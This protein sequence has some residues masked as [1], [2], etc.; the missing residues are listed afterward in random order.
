MFG[1]AKRRDAEAMESIRE[2]L[3]AA[4]MH[5]RSVLSAVAQTESRWAKDRD[6]R[7][8]SQ[9]SAEQAIEG[10]RSSVVQNAADV[11]NALKHV[12]DMCAL[13]V[14]RLEADRVDR[15][16]LTQ[17]ITLL[18]RQQS[19]APP[20]SAPITTPSSVLGGTII[21]AEST[22]PA[23]SP[24][25]GDGSNGSANGTNGAG[26]NGA[27]T[28]GA[29]MNGVGGNADID[30]AAYEAAERV[31]SSPLV[32]P[33]PLVADAPRTIERFRPF[34][35]PPVEP[36]S[37]PVQVLEPEIVDTISVVDPEPVA[38]P[39]PV[40]EPVVPAKPFDAFAGL[41][42]LPPK[43]V[44]APDVVHPEVVDVIAPFAAPAPAPAPPATPTPFAAPVP[45]APAPFAPVAPAPVPAPAPVV[46]DGLEQQ[47]SESYQLTENNSFRPHG[48]TRLTPRRSNVRTST[49]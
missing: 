31:A 18:A 15:R 47:W 16:E 20:V 26:T 46:S 45:P 24:S 12:S 4:D 37:E 42:L 40:A 17:A 34:A 25:N 21:A 23:S 39:V 29:G 9:L 41:P 3:A 8:R 43:P 13:V 27:G 49:N 33:A 10:V 14:E 48:G 22:R 19:A 38:P 7:S 5:A 28:N 6:E 35:T 32:E 11:S 30:L 2:Q 36:T 1:K 44:P